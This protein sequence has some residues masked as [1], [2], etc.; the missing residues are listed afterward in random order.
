MTRKDKRPTK[1]YPDRREK[2]EIDLPM[3]PGGDDGILP[4][5]EQPQPPQLPLI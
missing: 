4:E 5:P 3:E 1:I 2:P